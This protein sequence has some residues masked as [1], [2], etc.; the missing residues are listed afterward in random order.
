MPQAPPTR[1]VTHCLPPAHGGGSRS[2]SDPT[3]RSFCP[4]RLSRTACLCWCL[5][6]RLTQTS[7]RGSRLWR[8]TP[9]RG[10]PSCRG[11]GWTSCPSAA[12]C[13]PR[14]P[15]PCPPAQPGRGRGGPGQERVQQ[16]RQPEEHGAQPGG[17]ALHPAGRRAEGLQGPGL[18]RGGGPGAGGGLQNAGALLPGRHEEVSGGRGAP[19]GRGPGHG[20]RRHAAER[21]AAAHGQPAGRVRAGHPLLRAQVRAQAPPPDRRGGRRRLLLP[22][23]QSGAHLRPH[24]RDVPPQRHVFQRAA[25]P[26]RRPRALRRGRRAVR[27]RGRPGGRG[28]GGGSRRGRGGEGGGGGGSRRRGGGE[29]G[30]PGEQGQSGERVRGAGGGARGLRPGRSVRPESGGRAASSERPGPARAGPELRSRAGPRPS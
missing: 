7:E 19:P 26:A 9:W 8:R 5:P 27:H 30:G 24:R 12:S 4:N 20:A 15:P 11:S 14:S 17:G 6:V 21:E 1:P 29:G 2:P 23:H 25:G 18:H 22:V 16:R 10:C 28:G 3:D 13:C